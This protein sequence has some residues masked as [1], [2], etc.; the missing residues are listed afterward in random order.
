MS[1]PRLSALICGGMVVFL[2]AQFANA[3]CTSHQ[4]KTQASLLH[5]EDLWVQALND[6]S[7]VELNC[8]LAPDFMDSNWKGDLLNREQVL[9]AA[10]S[11]APVPAGAQHKFE[12]MKARIYGDT[13]IVTGVSYWIYADGSEHSRARFTD[14]FIYRDHRGQAV[15]GHETPVQT[16]K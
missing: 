3:D 10:A 14:V 12:D 4:P 7:A 5:M 11:R 16:A 2:L 6:R 8:L 13:G 1:C 15:S 9:Q